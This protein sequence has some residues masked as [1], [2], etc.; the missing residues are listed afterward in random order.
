MKLIGTKELETDRLILRKIKLEDYKK[1]YNNWCSNDN[2]SRYVVWNTHKDEEET[3]ELFEI[4]VEDYKNL[5]TFR[6]IVELKDTKE[7]IGTIDVVN[8][9]I[10]KYDSCEIGY[11]YGEKY[12]NNGYAT[13]ALKRVIKFLFEEVDAY[14]IFA[15]HLSNNPSS[16]KV[17]QKSGMKFDGK[18]RQR[19]LDKDGIRNDLL[20]YSITKEEYFKEK[21][22]E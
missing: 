7:L 6:W 15:D 19:F 4:W 17:M 16:G 13:E 8:K 10:L 3:K 11:C 5:D 21:N 12:W 9:K 18:L 1:A 2:V 22:N 14:I 20:C